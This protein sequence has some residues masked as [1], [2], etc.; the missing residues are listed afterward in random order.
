MTGRSKIDR[1]ETE[2]LVQ[3]RLDEALEETFPASDPVAV[4][5]SE[6]L[7]P[8]A[9]HGQEPESLKQAEARDQ[10]SKLSLLFTPFSLKSLKLKNRIVMAPMTRSCWGN[11]G[12]APHG[13]PG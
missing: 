3:A 9:D 6:H 13:A 12:A 5:R 10:S 11:G 7:G 2:D 1:L 8:P 4:G